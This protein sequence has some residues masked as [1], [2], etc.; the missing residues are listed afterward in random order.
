M[1]DTARVVFIEGDPHLDMPCPRWGR[2]QPPPPLTLG[3]ATEDPKR[4]RVWHWD[5]NV[6]APTIT[7]SIGCDS[8]CGS[9]RVITNGRY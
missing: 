9:H 5:G 2:C 3:D 6:D 1:A 8:K 4:G 7:P